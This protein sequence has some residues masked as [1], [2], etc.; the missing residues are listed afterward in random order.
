MWKYIANY[1][2]IQQT[3]TSTTSTTTITITIDTYK[4][5]KH[6][7]VIILIHR[8]FIENTSYQIIEHIDV[9]VDILSFDGYLDIF[10]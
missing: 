7:Y 5:Q 6:W 9:N 4:R 1:L 3:W 2:G 8:K 10:A